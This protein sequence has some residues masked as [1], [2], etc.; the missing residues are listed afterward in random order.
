MIRFS[1]KNIVVVGGTSGIGASVIRQ[2]LIEDATVINISRRE[3]ALSNVKHI[4]L[5][6]TTEFATIDGLPDQ[7]DG[8]VYCPGSINLKPFTSLSLPDFMQ[9]MNINLFGA[10]KVL[11]ACLKG[12][13]KSNQASVVLFSTVAVAQGMSYH[14]SIASAKGAVEGLTKSLAA[15]YSRQNIRF[16]AIAPSLTNTPLA[17]HLLA[18]EEKVKAAEDRHPLKKIGSADDIAAMALLL[19]SDQ[20]S[21]ITGQVIHLDGGMSSV[22]PI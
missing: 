13:R 20:G 15:E 7:I 17:A 2:L 18:S 4:S 19:L 16:N 6:I 21:W 11:K 14:A 22:R 1:G 10:V 9:E 3:L 5:D 12:L 8:L